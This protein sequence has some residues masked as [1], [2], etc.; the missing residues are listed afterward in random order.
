[1]KWNCTLFILSII[2][3][4]LSGCVK[5][6]INKLKDKRGLWTLSLE[7]I[8]KTCDEESIYGSEISIIQY[9]FLNETEV[10]QGNDTM[11]WELESL[12]AAANPS[13]VLIRFTS[14]WI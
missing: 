4:T 14:Q 9:N 8:E 10:V 3:F 1:M 6:K 7:R 2:C 12:N 13:N 11:L 5:I